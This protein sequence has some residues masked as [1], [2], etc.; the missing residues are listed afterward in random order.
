MAGFWRG[1]LHPELYHG[2][3]KRAPYFEGW[4]FKLV[5]AAQTRR[6]ALIPGVFMERDPAQS[7][8]F[9]QVL[10]GN[11]GNTTY[12]R[13][14][15]E[16]FHAAPDRFDV[17]VGPN[18]FSLDRVELALDDGAQRIQG[19]LQLGQPTPWPHTIIS[20]GAM[21]PFSWIPFMECYHGVLSMDH[22]LAGQLSVDGDP[23]SF[24]GGRGYV[25]KDWGKSFPA[26]WIWLQ[27]N[28]FD[29]PGISLMASVAVVPWLGMAFNG[30]IIGL[31]FQGEV[32][33][34]ATYTGAKIEGLRIAE[35]SAAW[36][37]RTRRY[38]LDIQAEQG[39]SGVLHGPSKVD[40]APRVA[41][42]LTGTIHI[43]FWDLAASP[44]ELLYEGTGTSAGVEIS[45]ETDHL[46]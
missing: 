45:G 14:P 37:V 28:H 38:Q 26:G 3:N 13:Y 32:I 39:I 44:R 31:L 21:G 25:E 33:R 15:L 20:P 29:Q 9:V 36:T 10:D 8:S 41:E 11:S 27:S 6:Y 43:R 35:K 16:A 4:Y 42:S 19:Q 22:G 30:F 24:D 7:H 5:D 18:R 17:L 1:M 2:V 12:H 23:I 40:M 34:F 46:R